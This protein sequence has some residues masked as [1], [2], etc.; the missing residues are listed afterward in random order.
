MERQK[1]DLFVDQLEER[2]APGVICD[3]GDHGHGNNG[4]GNGGDD[5]VPGRSADNDSPNAA[6]KAA[7]V[8]R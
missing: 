7:D 8:V 2:I 3:H 5:G 4:F 6:E 1:I